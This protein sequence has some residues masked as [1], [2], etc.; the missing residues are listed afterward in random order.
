MRYTC[1]PTSVSNN[2]LQVELTSTSTSQNA[3]QERHLTLRTL[4]KD[5][6]PR[7]SAESCEHVVVAI[8]PEAAGLTHTSP[9]TKSAFEHLTLKAYVLGSMFK[10]CHRVTNFRTWIYEVLCQSKIE[11][12]TKRKLLSYFLLPTVVAGTGDGSTFATVPKPTIVHKL[13]FLHSLVERQRL[14]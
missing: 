2:E 12:L 14:C 8:M 7:S 11:K 3:Q 10:Q 1:S 4:G 6:T 9:A 5:Q 13:C